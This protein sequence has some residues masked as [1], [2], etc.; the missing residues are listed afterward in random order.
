MAVRLRADPAPNDVA[1]GGLE[2]VEVVEE[3]DC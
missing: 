2:E 3:V 1:V